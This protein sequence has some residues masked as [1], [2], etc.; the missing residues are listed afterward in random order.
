MLEMIGGRSSWEAAGTV[1]VPGAGAGQVLS[2]KTDTAALAIFLPSGR[3]NASARNEGQTPAPSP[4]TT[5][6][7]QE[8]RGNLPRMPPDWHTRQIDG[9]SVHRSVHREQVHHEDERLAALDGV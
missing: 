4:S 2:A 9:E 6:M 1:Q 5:A 3:L 7:K 8:I